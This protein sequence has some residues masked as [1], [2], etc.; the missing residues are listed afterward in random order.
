[1]RECKWEFEV[2]LAAYVI[3]TY[4]NNGYTDANE[5]IPIK[6]N[7]LLKQTQDVKEMRR[8]LLWKG[9]NIIPLPTNIPDNYFYVK[10]A[11]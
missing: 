3:A 8:V 9:S 11:T 6:W 5:P 4:T 1:M 10:K 2:L 7:H